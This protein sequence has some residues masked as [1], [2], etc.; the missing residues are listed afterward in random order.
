MDISRPPDSCYSGFGASRRDEQQG[1]G[2][3]D[4]AKTSAQTAGERLSEAENEL[5]RR[6]NKE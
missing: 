1:E 2:V 4:A 3:W 5:W 6:I